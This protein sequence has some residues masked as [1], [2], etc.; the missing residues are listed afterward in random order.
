MFFAPSPLLLGYLRNAMVRGL[1]GQLINLQKVWANF[2]QTNE[3]MK[4]IMDSL[5]R[6]GLL[7]LYSGS[8]KQV[9]PNDPPIIRKRWM[10]FSNLF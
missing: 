9:L 8:E 1:S 5:E 6:T 10:H 2:P 4:R 3:L 7:K